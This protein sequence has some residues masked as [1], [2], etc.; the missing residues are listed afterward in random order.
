[1]PDSESGLTVTPSGT[2]IPEKSQ[3]KQSGDESDVRGL[4]GEESG[5]TVKPSGLG[6]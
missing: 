4:R 3:L 5:G 6:R 1:M 2:T